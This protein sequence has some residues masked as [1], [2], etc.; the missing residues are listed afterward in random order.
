VARGVL[1][2]A[3]VPLARLLSAGLVLLTLGGASIGCAGEDDDA[4]SS[5]DAIV[6]GSDKTYEHPEVGAFYT[7]GGLCT[8]TLIA[9]D[10]VVTAAHCIPGSENENVETA[11]YTFK[12]WTAPQQGHEFKVDRQRSLLSGS[13][14]AGPPESWRAQDILL[15]R[16]KD[17]VPAVL[18]R[19]AK[20]A[21]RWPTAGNRIAIFGFGCTDRATREGSGI[22][23]KA[24]SAWAAG[25]TPTATGTN[26]LCPGDSGGPLMNLDNSGGALLGTNSGHGAQGDHFG[27]LPKNRARIREIVTR[28][29]RER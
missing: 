22:K 20:I 26:N 13:D 12:I 21:T 25:A 19:P 15:L 24:E 23:R 2:G 10:V 5:D 8:G 27:D 16:L 1:L 9:A 18:A 7:A 6:N 4:S 11:G 17:P 29:S 28:W 14:F 3:F